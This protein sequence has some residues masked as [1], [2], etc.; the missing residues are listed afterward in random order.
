MDESRPDM[1]MSADTERWS[2]AWQAGDRVAIVGNPV[3]I[4]LSAHEGTVTG[5]DPEWEGYYLVQLDA[6]ARDWDTGEDVPQI[7][8][9]GDDLQPVGVPASIPSSQASDP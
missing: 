7:V 2:P 6:P 8:E 4:T 1:T 5:P 9:A 3:G